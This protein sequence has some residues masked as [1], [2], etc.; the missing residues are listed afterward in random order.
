MACVPQTWDWYNALPLL[1]VAATYREAYLLSIVSTIGGFIAASLAMS[2]HSQD[3]LPRLGGA[4]M[5][6]FAY[7]PAVIAVVRRPA[8]SE[9]PWWLAYLRRRAGRTPTRSTI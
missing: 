6:V 8:E 5:V 7:L 4:T 9:M 3:E 1:T 2:I